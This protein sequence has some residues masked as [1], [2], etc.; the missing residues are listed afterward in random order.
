MIHILAVGFRYST[1]LK[2]VVITGKEKCN[3]AP[4]KSLKKSM[5]VENAG[6]KIFLM[7][8]THLSEY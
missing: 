4:T 6:Y 7:H 5:D 3:N 2:L 1:N 8:S